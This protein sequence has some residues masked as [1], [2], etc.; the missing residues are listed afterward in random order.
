MSI[1]EVFSVEGVCDS[2][3]YLHWAHAT[4][5]M[6]PSFLAPCNNKKNGCRG[7]VLYVVPSPRSREPLAVGDRVRFRSSLEALWEGYSQE[8]GT[9]VEISATGSIMVTTDAHVVTDLRRDQ[10]VRVKE[11]IKWVD[12]E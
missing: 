4:Q 3:G 8:I 10:L 9:V 12:D 7:R 1:D 2:C 11:T 6:G 5:R